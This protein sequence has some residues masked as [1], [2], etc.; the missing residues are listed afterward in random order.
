MRAIC[1]GLCIK[2]GGV[3]LKKIFFP[4]Q[5]ARA[6]A[7]RGH[8]LQLGWM[9]VGGGASVCTSVCMRLRQVPPCQENPGR[10]TPAPPS[11]S[12]TQPPPPPPSPSFHPRLH[13]HPAMHRPVHNVLAEAGLSPPGAG[14]QNGWNSSQSVQVLSH[15]WMMPNKQVYQRPV[16]KPGHENA[17]HVQL[18]RGTFDKK[19]IAAYKMECVGQLMLSFRI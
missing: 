9:Q 5:H 7:C 16:E 15:S 6:C 10:I 11:P 4:C 18:W 14:F 8:G 12:Q 17:W 3:V 1:V 19:Y 13:L 2:D